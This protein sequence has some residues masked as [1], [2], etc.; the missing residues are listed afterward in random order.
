[1][2]VSAT[3]NMTTPSAFRSVGSPKRVSLGAGAIV[4]VTEPDSVN[5]N[6]FESRFLITC[7]SRCSSVTTVAGSSSSTITPNS[8]TFWSATGRKFRSTKSASAAGVTGCGFT[9]IFP[10]S[11]FERSRMS[12]I[13]SSRSE[14]A[15]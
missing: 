7:C 9:S 8:S 11:T 10:A 14:P 5:L 13:S 12:L 3:W 1:M 2:P 4:S 15:L 6:A